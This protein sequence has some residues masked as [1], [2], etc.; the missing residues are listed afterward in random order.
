MSFLLL[1]S[2]S[3]LSS[4]M[5]FTYDLALI[6]RFFSE[7]ALKDWCVFWWGRGEERREVEASS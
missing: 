3:L 7:F 2:T 5:A 6:L 4:T 1:G